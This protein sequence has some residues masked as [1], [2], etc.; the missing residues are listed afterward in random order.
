M[1]FEQGDVR[2]PYVVGG[3]FNGV[4]LPK[5]GPIDD[6]DGGSGAINRRRGVP[7]GSPDRLA[8]QDGRK[9][10]VVL[11]TG[12][13]KHIALDATGSSVTMHSDGRVTI[14]A[15]NGVTVDAARQPE[16]HGRRRL[17]QRQHGLTMD[18]GPSVKVN[19][20]GQAVVMGD[21]IRRTEVEQMPPAAVWGPKPAPCRSGP[22]ASRPSRSAAS[23]RR[24]SARRPSAPSPVRGA[25]AV[26]IVPAGYVGADR[27]QVGRPGGRQ[28]HEVHRSSWALD[29]P[30]RG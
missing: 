30:H 10:G 18:G 14:E 12:D 17:D 4:D 23:R 6:V 9:E 11:A 8:R 16:A 19:A 24:R 21:K 22:P 1:A 15:K 29:R 25:P 26:G 13:G 27:G 7:P 5:A 20:M 2:R 3:L 28:P